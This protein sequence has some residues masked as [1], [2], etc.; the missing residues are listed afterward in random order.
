VTKSGTGTGTVTSSPSGINCGATCTATFTN[1]TTVTLTATAGRKSHFTGWSG[2]CS[3]KS[4]CVLSMTGNHAVNASFK[5]PAAP[6]LKPPAC[7]VPKL[8]GLSLAKAK[9]KLRKA[10]CK[11]GKVTKKAPPAAQKG[12][13][14]GQ[15]PKPGRKLRN[16]AKVNV[17]V[18][19][20]P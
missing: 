10:H 16:G 12:K 3:G 8:R 1:G 9:A 4:S 7:K 18:G 5:G 14:I 19:K 15:K 17:T 2:D 20:G 11:L 6:P 13:V